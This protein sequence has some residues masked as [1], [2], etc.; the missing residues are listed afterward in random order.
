MTIQTTSKCF[1]NYSPSYKCIA[2][3]EVPVPIEVAG[4][5]LTGFATVTIAP[6]ADFKSACIVFPAEV[7]ITGTCCSKMVVLA[8]L[9]VKNVI[10]R[11]TAALVGTAAS[12]GLNSVGVG[13]GAVCGSAAVGGCISEGAAIGSAIAA[14]VGSTGSVVATTA[15]GGGAFKAWTGG[16]G[17]IL[18]GASNNPD[19]YGITY[20]CWKPV[21][22]EEYKEPSRGILLKELCVHP[23]VLQVAATTG[24]HPGL[25]NIVIENI[26]NELFEIEYLWLHATESI[27]GHAK[28]LDIV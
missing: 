24:H 6:A 15:L 17:L 3:E 26:W 27:V 25:P 23:N 4:A 21:I 18:I 20:D 16:A 12:M 10:S 14:G 13:W 19:E 2:S 5:T 22:H 1:A 7:I 28:Q 11:E 9:A 8:T